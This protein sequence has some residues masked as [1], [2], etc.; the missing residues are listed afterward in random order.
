MKTFF[1]LLIFLGTA[2][3]I[4]PTAHAQDADAFEKGLKS[5]ERRISKGQWDK[6]G[7]DLK[8]LLEKNARADYVYIEKPRIL[9][10]MERIALFSTHEPPTADEVL[11]A[12]VKK[13]D[14]ESGEIEMTLYGEDLSDLMQNGDAFTMPVAFADDY[15]LTMSGPK[16]PGSE[17]VTVVVGFDSDQMHRFFF[18]SVGYQ[19]SV[20][21]SEN[22]EREK[23]VDSA[24][25][26]VM[27]S[28]ESFSL[29]IE[30]KKKKISS[31]ANKKRMFSVKRADTDWGRAAFYG[32]ADYEREGLEIK[33]K[34]A[35][36]PAWIAGKIDEQMQEKRELFEE[37]YDAHRELPEWL[38]DESQVLGGDG[39]AAEAS[40]GG[41]R[42]RAGASAKG[43]RSNNAEQVFRAYPGNALGAQGERRFAEIRRMYYQEKYDFDALMEEVQEAEEEETL[44]AGSAAL[45]R[46][47]IYLL[48]GQIEEAEESASKMVAHDDNHLPSVVNHAELLIRLRDYAA[49]RTLLETAEERW[50]NSVEVVE[51]KMWLEIMTQH[52]E[53]A[54]ELVQNAQRKGVRGKEID[55][56]RARIDKALSGPIWQKTYRFQSTH[57]DIQ[58]D[59]SEEICKEA[60]DLLESAYTSYSVHLKR[61]R[62]LE[63]NKFRVF[64]FSGEASYQ[65]YAEDSL[66]SE[67]ENTAGLFSPWLK[68]LLIWNVP[69]R[70]MMF[71]TIVHEGFH[72]Y[73]DLVA[74]EAPRWFNEG[75]AEYMELYE[76]IDGRFVEGQVNHDHVALL[77]ERGVMPLRDF[78]SMPTAF[79]YQGDVS[80][81][82]AQGW[83]VM[84]FLRNGG[85][86]KEK[87]FQELFKGFSDSPSIRRVI[88]EVFADVDM[89]QFEQE[90]LDHLNGLE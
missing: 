89:D 49:S 45:L 59:I 78:L 83:A 75:M 55:R 33:I 14:A 29:S 87:M 85:N 44:H 34:G 2:C 62:G 7:K 46:M 23:L 31:K 72:Q 77:K 26:E 17:G 60:A 35:L 81:N 11:A 47:E 43:S 4:A 40:A 52:L 1:S 28:G 42:G 73:L 24:D 80:R 10:S 65:R 27:D 61:I 67:A 13:Y 3:L 32:L 41:L 57:Y 12:K 63:K 90:F 37:T 56:L 69:Q 48:Y 53:E 15:T 54:Q 19:P 20:Y 30:V 66:G 6:A 50:P 39:E 9:D 22:G 21:L 88:G 79:Y 51:A 18:G 64:L 76:T 82:Y 16:Y 38:F 58:S 70:E 8:S 5:V 36:E 68:Q 86:E 84:H 74:P 71:R 25:K